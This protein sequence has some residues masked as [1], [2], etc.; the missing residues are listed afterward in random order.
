MMDAELFAALNADP[1]IGPD[2]PRGADIGATFADALVLLK[3][4]KY[5]GLAVAHGSGPDWSY[6]RVPRAALVRWLNANKPAK[7]LHS[8][9]SPVYDE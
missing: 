7:P 5:V 2:G 6:V 3:R 8:R 1:C 4:A 9:L